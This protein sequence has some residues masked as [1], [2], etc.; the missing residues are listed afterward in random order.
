MI[1]YTSHIWVEEVRNHA[2]RWRFMIMDLVRLARGTRTRWLIVPF[3]FGGSRGKD[4]LFV[5]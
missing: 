2:A 1:L 3:F 5:K 4:E